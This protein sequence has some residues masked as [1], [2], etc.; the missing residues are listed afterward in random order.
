MAM[1]DGGEKATQWNTA[2]AAAQLQWETV[3]AAQWMAG[4]WH[5][6]GVQRR[7]HHERWQWTMAARCQRKSMMAMQ[8]QWAMAATAQWTV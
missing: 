5:N 6:R 2:M 7:N 3:V 8:L 4:W 1:G